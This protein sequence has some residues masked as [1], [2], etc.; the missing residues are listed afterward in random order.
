MGIGGTTVDDLTGNAKFPDSADAVRMSSEF[1]EAGGCGSNY[2]V[3][4]HGY[5]RPDTTGGYHFFL[6]SDGS[7]ALWLNTGGSIHLIP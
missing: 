5:F 7:S 3:M 2:G 4:V 6:N 1:E